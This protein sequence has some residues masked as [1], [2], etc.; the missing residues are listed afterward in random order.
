LN[1]KISKCTT[2]YSAKHKLALT[3]GKRDS[4]P[5]RAGYVWKFM[6]CIA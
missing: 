4:G 5:E 2:N 3:H 1:E 6:F